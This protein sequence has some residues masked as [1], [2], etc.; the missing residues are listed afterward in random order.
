MSRLLLGAPCGFFS[1]TCFFAGPI[2]P[3]TVRSLAAIS[4]LSF[5]YLT[6]IAIWGSISHVGELNP[7]I[8]LR[9]GGTDVGGLAEDPED[10]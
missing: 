3:Q 7:K 10:E 5:P 1:R 6:V 8:V 4:I 2:S 9:L